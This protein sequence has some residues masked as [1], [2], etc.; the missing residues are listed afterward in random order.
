METRLV[1][2]PIA[3]QS[4]P[5]PLILRKLFDPFAVQSSINVLSIESFLEETTDGGK[6]RYED[7][8]PSKE[9]IIKVTSSQPSK[10]T[11]KQKSCFVYRFNNWPYAS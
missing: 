11:K 3:S 4:K 8:A 7:V 10:K 6:R 5:T 9:L 2:F 1:V